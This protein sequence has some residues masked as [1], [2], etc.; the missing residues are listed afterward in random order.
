MCAP[1][2]KLV[3]YGSRKSKKRASRTAACGSLSL[4]LRG[5]GHS[6][7][8]GREQFHRRLFNP[9]KD[10]R[11]AEVRQIGLHGTGIRNSGEPH[12]VMQH[13]QWRMRV[14]LILERNE[15]R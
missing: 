8:F 6:R 11:L 3:R 1:P 12:R 5:F 14:T 4:K 10:G 15:Q 9:C 7:A 2:A 13:A